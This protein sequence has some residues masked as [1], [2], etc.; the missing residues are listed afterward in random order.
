VTVIKIISRQNSPDQNGEN[1]IDQ[2][3]KHIQRLIDKKDKLL[4]YYDLCCGTVLAIDA[5]PAGSK[6]Y[7]LVK[8][9]I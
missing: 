6:F 3:F 8:E 9:S 2:G 1:I 7:L 4:N 5:E